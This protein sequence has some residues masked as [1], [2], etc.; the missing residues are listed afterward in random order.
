MRTLGSVFARLSPFLAIAVVIL[1]LAAPREAWADCVLNG[2]TVTCTGNSPGGFAA[3]GGQNGLAV[4][5]LGGA[6]VGTGITLNN[7]NTVSNLG[8]VSVG[9]STTAVTV[10]DN[11]TVT[12]SGSIT[13]G[14]SGIGI[15]VNNGGRVSNSGTISVGDGGSGIL[16]NGNNVTISN[17]GTIRFS[18]C[19]LGIEALGTGM[20]ITNTGNLIGTGCGN[21]GIFAGDSS[22]ITNNGLIQLGDTGTGIEGGS[23]TTVVNNG[24]IIVGVD[25]IGIASNGNMTNNGTI[26]LGDAAAQGFTFAMAGEAD[27][28]RIINA[29]TITGGE[30]QTGLFILGNNGVLTNS[31]TITLGAGGIGVYVNG[32]NATVTNSGAITAGADGFGIAL[33]GTGNTVRNTGTITVGSCGAGID[34][35]IGGGGNTVI[36]SGR[37][38]GT[39]CDAAGVVLQGGDTLNNSGIISAPFSVTTVSGTTATVTNTGTLDGRIDLRAGSGHQLTNSGLITVSTA[40]ASGSGT[41]HEVRGTFTQTAAGTLALRVLPTATATNFDTFRVNGGTANLGGRLRVLVQ[42][43]LYGSTTVYNGVLSFA[44][45]NGT[46]AGIDSSTIF[47]NAAATYNATTI[48]LT[49][50]RIPFDQFPGGGSNG[51]AVGRALE[52]QYSTGLTGSAANFY[53]QLLQSTAPN[54]LSQLSGEVASAAQNASF[55]AFNQLFGTVFGQINTSRTAGTRQAQAAGGTRLSAELA[56][57]CSGDACQA[58][59]MAR[60]MN[61]WAQGFGAAGSYDASAAVGNSAVNVTSGGG[62]T[63]IDVQVT[64]NFLLGGMLGTTSASFTLNTAASTGGSQAIVFGAYASYTEGAAYVDAALAYGI[65]SFTTQ[66]Y[67]NTGSISEQVNGAFGGNQFGGRIESG[68]RFELERHAVTPYASLTVQALQQNGYTE[69]ARNTSTGAPGITALSV[70]GQT[71]TSVRSVLGAEFATYFMLAE[72]TVVRPRLR[73][74]WAH[75]FDTYRA[76]TAGFAALGPGVPFTVQGASPASDALIV[77]AAVEVELG[78]MVRIYGQFDGDFAETARSYAGTGGVRLRW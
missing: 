10:G 29:G 28:L 4:D 2:V 58:D 6:T 63:G 56:E 32:N 42:P 26:T 52:A 50:T 73:L 38:T 7:N 27:G 65:G 33:E 59:P 64:P 23:G 17:S 75:E 21:T 39:G 53:S 55:G 54:T 16:A 49:L 47:F 45:V 34:T 5:V 24:T 60:R 11:N 35:T 44:S 61:Y 14:L 40:L 12:S 78:G 48:D 68:W 62:A 43:G 46:F 22:S 18:E 41:A 30:N 3:G 72:D 37:I 15:E 19:G 71:T 66:R 25:G 9:D 70:Q 51:R 76:S 57:A 77:Q 1:S 31:G 36:N 74:G 8:T 13:S 67:I 69:T 20:S